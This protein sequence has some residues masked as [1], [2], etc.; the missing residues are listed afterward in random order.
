LWRLALEKPIF[1]NAQLWQFATYCLLKAT[2]KPIKQIV[3]RQVVE[4]APGQFIMT[5]DSAVKE[6]LSTPHKIRVCIKNLKKIGFV[7]NKSTNKY[8]IISVVNWNT[9]QGGEKEKTAET[10]NKQQTNNKQTTNK[11]IPTIYNKNIKNIKKERERKKKPAALKFTPP[12][13]SDLKKINPWLNATAW[14]EFIEHRNDKGARLNS[15]LGVTKNLNVLSSY[16]EAD[17]Q[18]VVDLTIANNWTG[19]FPLKNKTNPGKPDKTAST[20]RL[21]RAIRLR[22]EQYEN[23]AETEQPA[24]PGHCRWPK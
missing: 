2:H 10:A 12:T 17:Q 11:L 15:M 4:L 1:Q 7:T 23:E 8:T 9:Y 22:K 18:K 19:L 21:V 16:N 24:L 3:G 20:A 5:V 14:D 13:G 6:L